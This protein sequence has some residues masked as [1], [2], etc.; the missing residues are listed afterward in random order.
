[1]DL[2]ELVEHFG[3]S[4][5]STELVL[6]MDLNGYAGTRDGYMSAAS[7]GSN[8][9]Q[10]ANMRVSGFADQG[11][12]QVRR[13]LVKFDLAGAVAPG[14][15]ISSA[16]V[17]LYSYNPATILG[18]DGFYGLYPL[19]QDWGSGAVT[20][21]RA[22]TSA[23]WTTPGGVFQAVPDAL[24]ARHSVIEASWYEWDVTSRVQAWINDGTSNF[25]WIVKLADENVHAQDDFYQS[26]AT[27]PLDLR[28][29][30]VIHTSVAP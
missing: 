4:D 22:T 26:T 7:T 19:T 2:L 27:N 1:M 21:L 5:Q 9:N 13:S 25:G 23:T 28:P 16:K 30:L 18:T 29:K 14:T 15:A 24:V 6:Q 8:Y 3:E 17:C 11:A 12:S 10:V 20:W